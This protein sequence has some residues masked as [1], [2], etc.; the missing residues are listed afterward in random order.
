MGGT[1]L[2]SKYSS[3]RARSC[4][5]AAS[6]VSPMTLS[7]VPFIPFDLPQSAKIPLFS[8]DCNPVEFTYPT[9]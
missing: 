2:L 5:K 9:R 1:P 3:S 7:V 6:T 8:T 4:E